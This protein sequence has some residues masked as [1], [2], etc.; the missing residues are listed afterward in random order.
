RNAKRGFANTEHLRVK[1]CFLSP[2]QRHCAAHP[3]QTYCH[4]LRDKP[5]LFQQAVSAPL[6][7]DCVC[8]IFCFLQTKKPPNEALLHLYI[9]FFILSYAPLYILH[10]RRFM[11]EG[12]YIA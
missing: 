11:D 5:Q 10:F 4:L 12:C 3:K 7:E 1:G 8:H 9:H 2:L 6:V